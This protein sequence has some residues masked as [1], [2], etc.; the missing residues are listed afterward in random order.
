MI[1]TIAVGGPRPPDGSFVKVKCYFQVD[2]E[3]IPKTHTTPFVSFQEHHFSA[4]GHNFSISICIGGV[5]PERPERKDGPGFTLKKISSGPVCL[6][7]VGAFNNDLYPNKLPDLSR[8]FEVNMEQST[9]VHF[10]TNLSQWPP[11][12]DEFASPPSRHDISEEVDKYSTYRGITIVPFALYLKLQP[13]PDPT[14]PRPDPPF[15]PANPL[16]PTLRKIIDSG[17]HADV[18]VE[19]KWQDPR[20]ANHSE[21]DEINV[22]SSLLRMMSPHFAQLLGIADEK[23]YRTEDG[24][25]RVQFKECS[26]LIFR[27]TIYYLYGQEIPL[28]ALNEVNIEGFID[29]AN[30]CQIPKLKVH[31]E[32]IFVKE[33]LTFFQSPPKKVFE[34]AVA[35]DL[36]LVKE[37]VWQYLKKEPEEGLESLSQLQPST[38]TRMLEEA[39]SQQR[40]EV[41]WDSQQ[42]IDNGRG[43]D[44][45]NPRL[46]SISS[47][48]RH[49]CKLD[50]GDCDQG[51]NVM[52][53]KLVQHD[54]EREQKKATKK[55]GS[56]KKKK[57]RH[58][59]QHPFG[60]RGVES[61]DEF[62]VGAPY[63]EFHP[64]ALAIEAKRAPASFEYSLD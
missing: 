28:R 61:C 16:L 30:K 40:I 29:F 60:I 62:H 38:S 54:K 47:L 33:H 27:A 15:Y 55:A 21:R 64:G 11:M 63:V 5:R 39:L 57:P 53:E 8:P 22:C 23:Y 45:L 10:R 7:V 35:K 32:A 9:A 36:P 41:E 3:R 20:N 31:L 14:E 26:P 6:H 48:R 59:Q 19:V 50:L 51:R 17:E 1:S 4:L 58:T 37:K 44:K 43:G 42:L 34:W 13:N 46:L 25:R 49:I 24:P 12:C 2:E 52:V 56:P 18:V